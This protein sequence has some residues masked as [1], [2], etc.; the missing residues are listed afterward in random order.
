MLSKGLSFCPT[1]P[2]P[3]SE[4]H[5]HIFHSYNNFAKSLRLK[6]KQ[7][8]CAH[9]KQYHIAINPTTTSKVYRTM[10][11]LPPPSIETPQEYYTGIASLEN[12]IDNTKEL[13]ANNLSTICQYTSRNLSQQQF[14]A[15]HRLK[16]LRY[17]ITV[18]PADKNLGIVVMNTDDYLKQCM[19]QLSEETTYRSAPDY[20]ITEIERYLS[21]ILLS[22]KSTLESY[23]KR[24]YKHLASIPRH[25]R[26][27]Q[28]YGI[29]KIHKNYLHLPPL[30]PIISQ[31][32]SRLT[33]SAKLVDHVLQPLAQ[34]YPDYL[35]NSTSLVLLLEDVYVPDD[36]ILVSID[37]IS[38]YPSIPQSECL[39]IIY[40]EMYEHCDLLALD[41]NLIVRLLHLNM[42]YNYFKFS[43]LI[44]QQIKGTAMGAA[45]SP[46]IANI[47]MST[48]LN[49]FLQAQKAQP[50][51]FMRYIDD[52]FMIWKDTKEELNTFVTNLNSIHPTL[53]SL[54]NTRSKQLISWI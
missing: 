25:T 5:K 17:T 51:L 31:T 19:S 37:V 26:I 43:N 52:I 21:R 30:R 29:L 54:T 24:L 50:L 4:L 2:T 53:N 12:Y 44:F 38:L 36:A 42:N 39:D 10:K 15:L 46:S 27:P 47:Y 7:A 28:F 11:F 40:Q 22:F 32:M 49:K 48:V 14:T 33:P 23:N 41:P 13:V 9:C 18:K 20:P 35:H 3:P 8:Y 1:P 45:F 16:K 6:Y 34:T